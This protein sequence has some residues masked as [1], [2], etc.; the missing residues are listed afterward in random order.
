MCWM[1][2]LLRKPRGACRI[3]SVNKGI[4]HIGLAPAPKNQAT[5]NTHKC[6]NGK[7]PG[8]I[9]VHTY[10]CHESG[11]GSPPPSRGASRA[12]QHARCEYIDARAIGMPIIGVTRPHILPRVYA[13]M[14]NSVNMLRA[15]INAAFEMVPYI[16]SSYVP[17]PTTAQHKPRSHTMLHICERST[18]M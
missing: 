2:V 1:L 9:T 6:F 5:T 10:G 12:T 13:R 11:M 17:S 3:D 8:H 15:N 18:R 14:C 7:A 4:T 16:C